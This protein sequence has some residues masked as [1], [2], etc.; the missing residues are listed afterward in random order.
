MT[1]LSTWRKQHNLKND[2]MKAGDFVR[3][4]DAMQCGVAAL[5]MVC[6][7]FGARYSL[8][9]V[10]KFCRPTNEGVSLKGIADAAEHL[11]LDTVAARAEI[12]QLASAPLPAI[13]QWNQ[14]HFVV[15]HKVSRNGRRFHIA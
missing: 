9:F 15:L 12:A 11:G 10:A 1:P 4:R 8:D 7:H 6:R 3:Q 2:D 14:N 13:L 5:T